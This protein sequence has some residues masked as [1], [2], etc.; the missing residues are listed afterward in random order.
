[1][2]R[3]SLLRHGA[4]EQGGGFRGRLDDALTAQGWAQ[5]TSAVQGQGP[6]D[7]LVSSP[8][9]RCAAFAE[10]LAEQHGLPLWREADL[11]ELDFGDWEG[12]SAA[13]LMESQADLLGRFWADP[14]AVTPPN[15]EPM[16]AF[17]ARVL[18]AVQR[19]VHEGQGRHLLVVT[20]GG[21]MR[22]LLARARDL[23]PARLL[24]VEVAHG[25]LCSL[26]VTLVDG[27][28]RFQEVPC[29]RC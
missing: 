24:E 8:L 20:H 27:Q 11:R 23:A 14:Y 1:M 16:Q 15:G 13:E 12:R 26:Q 6:W 28:L 22:L 21:V 4:T 29:S 3:L 5:M 18:G 2:L 9:R 25:Q 17:E 7:G 19:L 10:R